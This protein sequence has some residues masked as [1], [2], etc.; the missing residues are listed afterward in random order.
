MSKC[1][2]SVRPSK[3][4]SKQVSKQAS[5]HASKQASKQAGKQARKQAIKQTSKHAG[6]HL[7]GIQS[8]PCPIYRPK[9]TLSRIIEA[10]TIFQPKISVS[11][12]TLNGLKCRR[13]EGGEGVSVP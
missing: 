10:L 1:R 2:V 5:K 6:K 12:M 4:A 9:N 8:E 3:Q 13:C 7:G 11:K